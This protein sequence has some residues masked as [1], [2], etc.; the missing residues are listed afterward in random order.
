MDYTYMTTGGALVGG[1]VP[2]EINFFYTTRFNIGSIVL[3]KPKARK[4]IFEK[5]AIKNIRFS[6][7]KSDRFGSSMKRY[8]YAPLYIDSYNGYHNEED[9][10]GYSEASAL[11]EAYRIHYAAQLEQVTR[12]DC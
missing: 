6:N 9:L 11:A 2:F 3:S 7:N 12:D 1:C 5:I 10:C 8:N 4:G